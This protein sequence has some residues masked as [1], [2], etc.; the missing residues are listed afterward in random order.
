MDCLWGKVDDAE[1]LS[2]GKRILS[3]KK[4]GV[5]AWC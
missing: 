1:R 3:I 2:D 4:R 5:K